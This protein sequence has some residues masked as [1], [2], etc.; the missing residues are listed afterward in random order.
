PGIIIELQ[1]RIKRYFS[2][3]NLLP[4]LRNANKSKKGRQMRSERREA[5]LVLLA[6]IAEHMDL[7]SLRCGIPTQN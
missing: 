2:N 4:S 6:A 5:C 3:P 7:V 1:A